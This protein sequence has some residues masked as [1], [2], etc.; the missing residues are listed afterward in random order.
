[1]ID[2]ELSIHVLE[3]LLVCRSKMP[4]YET[5]GRMGLRILFFLP[6]VQSKMGRP[7]RRPSTVHVH[8]DLQL[9]QAGN[10]WIDAQRKGDR[11]L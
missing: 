2:M 3:S 4:A 11:Y 5:I 1:M 10:I 6:A 8:F 7:V 9:G